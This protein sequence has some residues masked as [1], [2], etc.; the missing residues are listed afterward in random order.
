MTG[1]L[2]SL[3]VAEISETFQSGNSRSVGP[4]F[5]SVPHKQECLSHRA[6]GLAGVPS[7]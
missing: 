7:T 2:Y 3:L 5:Q 1:F 4:T 6:H